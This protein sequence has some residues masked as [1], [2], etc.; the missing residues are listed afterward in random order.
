[1]AQFLPTASHMPSGHLGCIINTAGVIGIIDLQPGAVAYCAPKR[2]VVL[3]TKQVVGEYTQID[4]W[5]HRTV[6]NRYVS[7][8]LKIPR[9]YETNYLE[10][11][12]Y[13]GMLWRLKSIGFRNMPLPTTS[14]EPYTQVL[15]L[16]FHGQ[17]VPKATQIP[18]QIRT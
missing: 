9:V 3:S 16:F 5:L 18:S 14:I 12:L 11:S 2:A 7:M 10:T 1:M 13:S 6:D 4:W 17:R 15:G 8:I